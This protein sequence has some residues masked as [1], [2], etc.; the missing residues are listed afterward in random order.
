MLLHF[1]LNPETKQR[2]R[3]AAGRALEECLSAPNRDYIAST[4]SSGT[5]RRL[6]RFVQVIKSFKEDE[7]LRVAVSLLESLFKQSAQTNSHLIELSALDFVLNA[8]KAT[9]NPHTLRHAALAL[10]NL[11][12]YS[13]SECQ[14]RMISKNVPD[15][16][17]LLASSQDDVTRYYACLAICVLVS[18]KEIETAVTKSGTLSL[19]EPFLLAHKPADFATSDYKHCQG[20]PM[21]WLAKLVPVLH[22]KRRESRAMAAFHFAMEAGIKKDQEALGVFEQIGAVEALKQVAAL[23]EEVAPKFASVA[24]EIVGEEVPYKLSHQVPLWSVEDVQYW[25]THVS[26]FY[27]FL[28]SVFLAYWSFYVSAPICG[29]PVSKVLGSRFSIQFSVPAFI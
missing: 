7:E 1:L 27:A 28:P 9:T 2:V 24:L 11:S 12:M 19:V 5:S 20:R 23:P 13:D 14:Q 16:L 17:F 15:W 18:N 10:A 29:V 3:L 25:V 8:C 6:E 21:Q 22:A 26:P 4:D